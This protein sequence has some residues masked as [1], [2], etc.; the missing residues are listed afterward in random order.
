LLDNVLKGEVWENRCSLKSLEAIGGQRIVERA[1]EQ[2]TK[3]ETGHAAAIQILGSIQ[4]PG[5]DKILSKYMWEHNDQ[6]GDESAIALADIGT[7]YAISEVIRY[8][9]KLTSPRR[10]GY[11]GSVIGEKPRSGEFA[12]LIEPLVGIYDGA[13]EDGKSKV[14]LA[15]AHFTHKDS[16]KALLEL[17]SR[18]TKEEGVRNSRHLALSYVNL[19]HR[20][21]KPQSYLAPEI[22]VA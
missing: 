10:I 20:D 19:V 7:P 2:L 13:S 8:F 3:Y 14:L 5:A 12:P 15:I 22:K 18:H 11:V 1:I 4:Y 9:K 17:A 6:L 16:I 21:L